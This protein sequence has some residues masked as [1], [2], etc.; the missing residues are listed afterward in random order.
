MFSS[1]KVSDGAWSQSDQAEIYG[2]IMEALIEFNLMLY[3]IL[4]A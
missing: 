1:M 3:Y 2:P 4:S